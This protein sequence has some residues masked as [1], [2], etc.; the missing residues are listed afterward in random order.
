MILLVCCVNTH[1]VNNRFYFLHLPAPKVASCL[2]WAVPVAPGP[3]RR[4]RVVFRTT[5]PN[6]RMLYVG[7]TFRVRVIF[8]V[9]PLIFMFG[10]TP[11]PHRLNPPSSGLT[12]VS[13]D[14]PLGCPPCDI[15][16]S[17]TDFQV[18]GPTPPLIP[19]LKSWILD[20]VSWTPFWA[21]LPNLG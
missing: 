4:A 15:P 17:R 1:T 6:W 5:F 7:A 13:V 19:G 2:N 14:P 10:P 9:Q 8:W 21:D 11:P 18:W 20:H 12:P 3:F 16:G